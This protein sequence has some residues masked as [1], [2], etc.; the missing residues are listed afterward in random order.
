M[1]AA[2]DMPPPAATPARPLRVEAVVFDFDGTLTEPGAMDFSVV[3][4]EIGCP[5]GTLTLEYILSLET[6]GPREAAL[7]ALERFEA[8]GAAAAVPAAGAEALVH[9]LRGLGLPL[10]IVTRNGRAAIERAFENFAHIGPGDFAVV[11]TRDDDIAPKPAPDSLRLAAERI[12]VAPQTVLFVGDFTLDMQTGRAAGAITVFLDVT[13]FTPLGDDEVFAT[14]AEDC[15]FV[16][17]KLDEVAAIVT[18]GRPAHG[19]GNADAP[20]LTVGE[21][22]HRFASAAAGE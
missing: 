17:T 5:P 16:V 4:A 18:L 2:R 21:A 11:L 13:D 12:G 10:G 15:D 6:G 22:A 8:H 9:R 1:D 7:A 3:R 20:P 19:A 14:R